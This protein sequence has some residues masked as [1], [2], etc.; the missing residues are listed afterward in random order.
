MNRTLSIKC[1]QAVRERT[2][3]PWDECTQYPQNAVNNSPDLKV[4]HLLPIFILRTLNHIPTCLSA[5]KNAA[6]TDQTPYLSTLSTLPTTTTTIY[7]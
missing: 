7:I 2:Q 6:A 5:P 4:I 3:N 1:A